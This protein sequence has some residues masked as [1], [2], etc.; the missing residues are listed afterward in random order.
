MS[1]WKGGVSHLAAGHSS[2]T[3]LRSQ[4]S[5]GLIKKKNKK[6]NNLS[7]PSFALTFRFLGFL[8]VCVCVCVR[9]Q[10]W[11]GSVTTTT[12]HMNLF[13]VKVV[14]PGRLVER[15]RVFSVQQGGDIKFQ[16]RGNVSDGGRQSKCTSDEWVCHLQI[17]AGDVCKATFIVLDS[18]PP[19]SGVKVIGLLFSSILWAVS[20]FAALPGVCWR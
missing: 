8:S 15:A 7:W 2:V 18:K 5:T 3:R 14:E 19:L 16:F 12:S 9:A 1:D 20:L 10:R 6:K 13:I 17:T 4:T 11:E